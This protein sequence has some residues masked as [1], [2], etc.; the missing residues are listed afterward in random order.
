MAY[1]KLVGQQLS[2]YRL[3]SQL[4]VGAFSEV[5]LGE[6]MYLG[7]KAAIKVLQ[8]QLEGDNLKSRFLIEARTMASLQHPNIVRILD[9]GVEGQLLFLIVEYAPN[10]SLAALYRNV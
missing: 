1:D 4:G 5:Y 6:H 9:F 2:G 7:T 8:T 10:G 3:I